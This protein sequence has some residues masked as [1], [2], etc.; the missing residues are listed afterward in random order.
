MEPTYTVFVRNWYKPGPYGGRV[1]GPGRK[2]TIAR[3]VTW[4][5]ARDICEV[6][7]KNHDPGKYSRKAEFT[8][9]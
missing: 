6:Y 1:P 7:N 3:H 4:A 5:Q 8:Q 9:E 2:T